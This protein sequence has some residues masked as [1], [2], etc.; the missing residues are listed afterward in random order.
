M[1]SQDSMSRRRFLG[2]A[3]ALVAGASTAARAGELPHV[4]PDDAVA[5]SLNYVDDAQL[6]SKNKLYEKGSRCGSCALFQGAKSGDWGG[7]AT[8]P[9]KYVNQNGWCSAYAPRD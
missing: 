8:F 7:C 2:C 6:A 5:K 4:S 9:G 1:N 3:A